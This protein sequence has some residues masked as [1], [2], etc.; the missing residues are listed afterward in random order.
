MVPQRGQGVRE[1]NQAFSNPRESLG[2]ITHEKIHAV[3]TRG[4]ANRHKRR[5]T[6][7][8]RIKLH[9]KEVKIENIRTARQQLKWSS[10]KVIQQLNK[11]T[12]ETLY[13][14]LF[15]FITRVKNVSDKRLKNWSGTA[16]SLTVSEGVTLKAVVKTGRA[17][18]RVAS[19]KK[20][21]WNVWKPATLED[22]GTRFAILY[23]DHG[24]VFARIST[25]LPIY[26]V[27]NKKCFSF[28][29][30]THRGHKS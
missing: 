12:K 17:Q 20:A 8:G 24:T 23:T 6:P 1:M 27:N 18:S 2:N 19:L 30:N 3:F 11:V 29:N 26:R 15:R 21:R 22:T 14:P 16:R 5:K 10:H 28:L 4:R 9:G 7:N 13:D 25:I